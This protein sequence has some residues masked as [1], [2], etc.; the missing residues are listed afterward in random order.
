MDSQTTTSSPANLAHAGAAP[1][2]AES[3]AGAWIGAL[4]VILLGMVVI[5]P[6]S[7]GPVLL[8]PVLLEGTP[9]L[10]ERSPASAP[11]TPPPM[12]RIAFD[13]DTLVV[14]IADT[15]IARERGLMFRSELGP[16]DGMLFVYPEPTWISFWMKD[17]WI[18]LDL[19]F[20]DD[21]GVVLEIVTLEAF[22]ERWHAS[23]Q[24]V[25]YALEVNAGW[26]AARSIEAGARAR[27]E[28]P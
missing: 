5:G 26:F 4:G 27:I 14:E 10:L 12:A 22:S 16:N 11:W 28:I 15:D 18:P 3:R 13:A 21:H 24:S 2:H 6:V 17:T 25:R 23:P 9:V 8:R 7:L 1:A 19:A 20:F